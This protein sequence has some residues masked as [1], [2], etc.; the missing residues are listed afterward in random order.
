MK[1]VTSDKIKDTSIEGFC[2]SLEYKMEYF[3]IRRY[4]N[5]HD[6]IAVGI[7]NGMFDN[8]TC[9]DFW[10][11]VLIKSVEA[12]RPL[13]DFLRL[14]QSGTYRELVSLYTN[15]KAMTPPIP[16]HAC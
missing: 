16:A 6:L 1:T 7:K 2:I 15:W 9:F 10:S 4:L 12:S 14:K 3:A 5:I 13:I 8:Q 11:D